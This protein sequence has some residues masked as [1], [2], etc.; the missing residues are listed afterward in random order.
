[1]CNSVRFP[2]TCT[3]NGRGDNHGSTLKDLQGSAVT[4]RPE[5]RHAAAADAHRQFDHD[6]FPNLT[7]PSN[8]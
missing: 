8:R 1:L 5:Q 7:A 2:H 6:L 3:G 4:A